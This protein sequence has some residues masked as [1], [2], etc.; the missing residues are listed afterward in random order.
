MKKLRGNVL[1]NF[2][3]KQ[4]STDPRLESFANLLANYPAIQSARNL[5]VASACCTFAARII[6]NNKKPGKG[7]LRGHATPCHATGN[8]AV[9]ILY[10]YNGSRV[11]PTTRGDILET[12]SNRFSS[13]APATDS[14]LARARARA[15]L[16]SDPLSL[17]RLSRLRVPLVIASFH[18]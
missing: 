13:P 4:P 18:I 14:F 10:V 15:S 3:A 8:V 6:Q 2:K 5:S 12:V 9:C 11:L 1:T 16:P 17:A 7:T